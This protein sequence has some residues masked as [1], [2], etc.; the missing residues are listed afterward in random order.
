MAGDGTPLPAALAGLR[1]LA[2]LTLPNYSMITCANA[3]E[4]ARMANYVAGSAVYG[5]Q[6]LTLDGAPA[7]ASSG[8]TLTPTVAL[9]AAAPF[10]ILFVCGGIDVRHAVGRGLK[11]ALRRLA[12]EGAALGA[13][14]TGSFALAEAGLLDG[15]RCAVHWENLAAIVEEFPAVEFV[16]D[17]FVIDRGRITCTGGVAPLDLMLTLI[18]ARLGHDAAALVADQFMVERARPASDP[19]HVPLRARLGREHP[20][21]TRVVGLMERHVD[22]PLDL[23]RLARRAGLSERQIERLFR[24]HLRRTPS[25]YYMS[26]RLERARELLR[27]TPMPVTDVGVATGF[28]SASHFSTAYRRRFGHAPRAERAPA[29]AAPPSPEHQQ[30]T[31]PP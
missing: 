28:A 8:M 30:P 18:E 23:A 29:A 22:Q 25:D 3:L 16:Q 27:Q 11:E 31:A 9:A 1:R 21:I 14:C 7:A 19:Q 6:V 4:A 12:R 20:A 15:H 10:D 26:L 17:L 5:W 13:F 2:F 24:Q